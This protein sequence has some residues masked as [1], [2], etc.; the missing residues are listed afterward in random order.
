MHASVT[1]ALVK[2]LLTPGLIAVATWFERRWGPGVGGAIV[3]LPLTSA[4]VSVFLALE[5]GPGFAA[6]AA[7]ATLLGLLSQGALCLAYS[8]AARR[9]TWWTSVGAGVAAFV[10]ATHNLELA[11]RADRVVRIVDGRAVIEA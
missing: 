10:V 8:W 2:L 4:P 5:Q 6:A 1:P 11:R 9:A 3:G 7:V